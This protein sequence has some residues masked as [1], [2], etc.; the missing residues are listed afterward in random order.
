MNINESKQETPFQS[1]V[2]HGIKALRPTPLLKNFLSTPSNNH[3]YGF[4]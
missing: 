3:P 1:K 2:F 4:L